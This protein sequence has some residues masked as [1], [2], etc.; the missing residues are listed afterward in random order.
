MIFG[1]VFKRCAGNF[2]GNLGSEKMR[3]NQR[4]RLYKAERAAWNCCYPVKSLSLDDCKRLVKKAAR[5]TDG[6]TPSVL[7]GRGRRSA[8]GS[9]YNIKLPR[10]ART[11]WII[12]HEYTHAITSDKHGP[13][14]AKTYLALVRRFIGHTEGEILKIAYKQYRVKYITR[15]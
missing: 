8:W 9:W 5:F 2:G 6:P 13:S 4:S 10:W 12:L 7:D 14:F 11:R 15:R 3:D 1:G